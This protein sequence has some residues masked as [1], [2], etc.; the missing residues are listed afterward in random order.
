MHACGTW[1]AQLGAF[2]DQF[3]VLRWGQGKV[4]LE[5]CGA[6]N[7]TPSLIV[8]NKLDLIKVQSGGA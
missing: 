7:G 4:V 3:D 5:G 6:C 8:Q 1:D 2:V